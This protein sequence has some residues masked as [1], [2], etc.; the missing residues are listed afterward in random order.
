MAVKRDWSEIKNLVSDM[1]R[2]LNSLSLRL[3]EINT[4]AFAAGL[5]EMSSAVTASAVTVRSS[6]EDLQK[7]EQLLRL[8]KVT[9]PGKLLRLGKAAEQ[10]KS[11]GK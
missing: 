8:E 10:E 2:K 4:S 7:L 5:P 9:R 3:Q 6:Q 1:N 11:D